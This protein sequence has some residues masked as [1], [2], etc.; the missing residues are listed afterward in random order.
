MPGVKYPGK[1]WNDQEIC[2]KQPFFL[3]EPKH[4]LQLGSI[5]QICDTGPDPKIDFKLSDLLDVISSQIS[6][7]LSEEIYDNDFGESI[8]A[9]KNDTCVWIVTKE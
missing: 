5:I 2:V 1:L 6:K 3:T 4:S 9:R 7:K 8:Y